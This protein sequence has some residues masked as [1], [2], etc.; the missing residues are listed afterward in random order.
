MTRLK[1]TLRTAD[2][3]A[4]MVGIIVGS[5]IFR[6]PGI[7]ARQLGRPI[8]TFVAWVL[9]GA[10]AFLG[11]LVFAEL[12]AAYRRPGGS[13]CLRAGR[14]GGG[15]RSG[16]VGGQRSAWTG[17]RMPRLVRSWGTTSAA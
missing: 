3:L 8:L 2:G 12:A 1:R 10:L 11:T 9:G 17:P 4:M 6:T 5:G 16:S 7:V 14:S 13:M 15:P